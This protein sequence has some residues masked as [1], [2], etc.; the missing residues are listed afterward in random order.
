[1]K[2]I[3]MNIDNKLGKS[4][5]KNTLTWFMFGFLERMSSRNKNVWIAKII[6]IIG[7]NT[8]LDLNTA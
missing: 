3:D 4:L 2:I 7:L 6:T 5:K 1:M 8:Y